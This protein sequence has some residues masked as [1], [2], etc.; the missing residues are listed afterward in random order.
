MTRRR[1]LQKTFDVSASSRICEKTSVL[2]QLAAI[3]L[4]LIISKAAS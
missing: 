3:T 1:E 2:K 4:L